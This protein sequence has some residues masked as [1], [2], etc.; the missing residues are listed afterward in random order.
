MAFV[1]FVESHPQ[2][3][4]QLEQGGLDEYG[5][6]SEAPPVISTYQHDHFID[7]CS[8]YVALKY[9]P[10]GPSRQVAVW[11]PSDTGRRLVAAY[12]LRGASRPTGLLLYGAPVVFLAGAKGKPSNSANSCRQP[13]RWTSR[14]SRAS[15]SCAG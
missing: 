8:Y 10:D 15:G 6:K 5:E 1:Q 2:V 13:W 9:R 7:L 4:R 11:G 3:V 14:R 12:G